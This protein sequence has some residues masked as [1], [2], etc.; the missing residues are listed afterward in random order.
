MS[1]RDRVV[2][3]TGGGRGIGRAMALGL[4][5]AG[6]RV[7][8]TASHEIDE[9]GRA[10]GDRGLA[11]VADVGR[12]EDCDR[13][14]ETTL[15]RFARL[16]V[17]VN[18]AG[19]GMKYVSERF[20]SEP[21]PFWEVTPEVQRMIVDTNVNGPFFMARAAVR[22]MI[23]AGWGRIVNV[24]ASQSTMS[25]AGTSPYGS[26]K[27]ALE[28]ATQ[29]WSNDLARTGVTVNAL[30]PGGP[31]E[32][33]MVPS[34]VPAE[35]RAKM[36]RPEIMVAP[37]LWLASERSDGVSGRRIVADRWRD[38]APDAAIEEIREERKT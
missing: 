3:V 22:T 11:L 9:T 26:S 13:V 23:A 7:V 5:D 30:L 34:A 1:V 37:I 14:I 28:S 19:R 10:L 32:T 33:G 2:V 25:R 12:A 6:A 18:N 20:L 29:I 8:V 4:A 36:R 24:S 35:T 38:D 27:A 17:L 15:S 16:D 21:P 31:V